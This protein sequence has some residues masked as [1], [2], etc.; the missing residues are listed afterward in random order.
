MLTLMLFY[1][2]LCSILG[3]GTI[4]F[5]YYNNKKH[6]K[7]FEND[8]ESYL[9]TIEKR[10]EGNISYFGQKVLWNRYVTTEQ[11]DKIYNDVK[12]LKDEIQLDQLWKEAHYKIHGYDPE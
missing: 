12:S 7:N 3:L 8:W 2:I 5:I 9:N 4:L 1:I 6:R 10:N 11:K